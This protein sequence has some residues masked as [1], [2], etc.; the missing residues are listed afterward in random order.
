MMAMHGRDDREAW[1]MA[2]PV[3]SESCSDEEDTIEWKA[4]L[5][6]V[7]E[8][9]ALR[10]LNRLSPSAGMAPVRFQTVEMTLDQKQRGS[11]QSTGRR[12]GID[13]STKFVYFRAVYGVFVE[14]PASTVPCSRLRRT[15]ANELEVASISHEDEE[16]NEEDR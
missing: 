1:G 5:I 4:T 8:S 16:N 10:F 7:A 12:S 3:Y 11:G 2:S 15:C 9:F 6:G 13:P 14:D